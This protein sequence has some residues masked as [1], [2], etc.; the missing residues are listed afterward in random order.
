ML[1]GAYRADGGFEDGEGNRR[2]DPGKLFKHDQRLQI[3][4]AQAAQ[5]GGHVDAKE[6]HVGIAPAPFARQRLIRR[7]GFLGN[8]RQ[9]GTGETPC[10][11]LQAALILV[12]VEIHTP[13]PSRPAPRES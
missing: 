4:E 13:I 7:L 1:N 11:I 9:F 5:V 3:A 8:G 12:E 6:A 10:R 2:R